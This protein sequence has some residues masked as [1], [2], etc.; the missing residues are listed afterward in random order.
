MQ[1][2]ICFVSLPCSTAFDLKYIT[3]IAREK[4]PILHMTFNAQM[5]TQTKSSQTTQTDFLSSI[6]RSSN[7]IIMNTSS[8][9]RKW[10]PKKSQMP[11]LTTPNIQ[12]SMPEKSL[13]LERKLN[14]FPDYY[15]VLMKPILI[16]KL[17]ITPQMTN[18]ANINPDK[19]NKARTTPFQ[20]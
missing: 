4:Q 11:M 13:V 17:D 5:K 7:Y 20:H 14:S 9:I 15:V 3:K 2:L 8:E 19:Q 12:V 10:T 6:L 18:M 16:W 1:I